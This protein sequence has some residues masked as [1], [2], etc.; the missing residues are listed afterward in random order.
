LNKT[1]AFPTQGDRTPNQ[2][3]LRAI[4]SIILTSS[5]E[6]SSESIERRIVGMLMNISLIG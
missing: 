2:P 6:G 4:A 3:A 1:A 5:L